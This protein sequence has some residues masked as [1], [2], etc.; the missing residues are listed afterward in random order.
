MRQVILDILAP[1]LL[2][3]LIGALMQRR[4]RLDLG[5]LAKL[6]I[7]VFVPAFVFDKVTRSQLGLA[8]MAGVV[9]ITVVHVICLGLLVLGIGRLLRI[10]RKVL[11]AVMLAVMFYNSGNY[12]LPL[13]EL[14]YPAAQ[15][16]D[17]GKDGAAA[18]TFVLMTQ[19]LA[20]FTVG[21]MIAAWAGAGGSAARG[22]VMFLKLPILP[23]LIAALLVRY[24]TGGDVSQ[25][26]KALTET[27][28]YLAGGLV[29][30][31]LVTLGA[32]LAANPRWPRWKPVSLVVFLRLVYAPA[33]MLAL[34]WLVQWWTGQRPGAA[35]SAMWPW[36]AEL[37]I[38]TAATPSAINMLLLTMEL[39]GDAD[40]AA[41]CVFWTTVCSAVT[42]TGWLLF[43][44]WGF[45]A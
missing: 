42:I 1:I 22:I 8:E 28:R 26:P 19:N 25:M 36:P 18:Q 17:T 40:L 30:I 29:P 11:A 21:A 37:L 23:S 31:A 43:V 4:F 16:V 44:R 27:A 45:G 34:L 14:A 12:G 9:G 32:Q 13:A 10:D 20:T 24:W 33:Q 2:M 38:L 3:V 41:D 39:D 7:F 6:N 15:A 35:L 5:T